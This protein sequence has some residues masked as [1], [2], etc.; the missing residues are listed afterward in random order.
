MKVNMNIGFFKGI[1]KDDIIFHYTKSTTAIDYILYNNELKFGR[2]SQSNDPIESNP[3]ERCN[4]Y[5]SLGKQKSKSH[6]YEVDELH[7]LVEDLEMRFHQ[8]SFCKN[9]MGEE[10]ESKY[11]HTQFEGHEELFG[12]AKPRMW[13]QYADRFTGVCLAFSKNKILTLN[14]LKLD[15]IDDY[16]EYLTFQQLREKKV[17][18]IQGDFLL[19][20]GKLE[21]KTKLEEQIKKS[22][23]YKHQDYSGENEYRIGTLY[24]KY[25][26]SVDKVRG[27]LIFDESMMLDITNCIE[28]IFVSNY[29]NNRQKCD[30]LVYAKALNVPLVE[31]NWLY[32]SIECGNYIEQLNLLS[33]IEESS[34]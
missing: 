25:K 13:D 23:F 7:E 33:L 16:M 17:G 4:V 12:F 34:L 5:H 20:V 9:S 31:I 24:D 11:C 2:G 6:P 29:A 14:D 8:I 28:A 3:A 18:N 1:Y 22:F 15:L 27:K 30:L 21:Y 19:K 26:C 32:N 10:F